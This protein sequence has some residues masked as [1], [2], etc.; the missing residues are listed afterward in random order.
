MKKQTKVTVYYGNHVETAFTEYGLGEFT[1]D[2]PRWTRAWEI[3]MDGEDRG[4][5]SEVA[6]KVFEMANIEPNWQDRVDFFG[7]ERTYQ[8]ARS[9]SKGDVLVLTYGDG[10]RTTLGC[11]AVG[12]MSI[13]EKLPS[14]TIV[15]VELDSRVVNLTIQIVAYESGQLDFEDTVALF[16]DLLRTKVILGLQGSCQRTAQTF[17]DGGVLAIDGTVID[18]GEVL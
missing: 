18:G 4:S 5:P 15:E 11:M 12:W 17:I 16:S 10:S 14:K 8:N 1:T 7:V 6:G 13:A 3:V 9:M 2:D